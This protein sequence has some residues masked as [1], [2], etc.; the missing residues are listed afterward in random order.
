M[1]GCS[2][3]QMVESHGEAFQ[4]VVS[5]KKIIKGP[6]CMVEV[7]IVFVGGLQTPLG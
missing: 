5:N 1:S 3:V 2:V 6:T 4:G 7:R